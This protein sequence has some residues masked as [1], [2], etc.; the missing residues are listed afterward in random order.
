[1]MGG[2]PTTMLPLKP[3]AP[4]PFDDDWQPPYH[5]QVPKP[6]NVVTYYYSIRRSTSNPIPAEFSPYAFRKEAQALI[7]ELGYRTVMRLLAFMGT[8]NS[9][10]Y[11]SPFALSSVRKAKVEMEAA[12]SELREYSG[13]IGPT[14]LR[15]L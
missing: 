14:G 3:A 11:Q 5:L 12:R 6:E 8:A 7:S 10:F 13:F 4:S 2:S 9:R 1:M 15:K